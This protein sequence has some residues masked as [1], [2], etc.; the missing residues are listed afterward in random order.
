MSCKF[1]LLCTDAFFA[2]CYSSFHL[3]VLFSGT[4]M[5]FRSASVLASFFY[6]SLARVLHFSLRGVSVLSSVC[7]SFQVFTFLSIFNTAFFARWP[8]RSCFQYS[9]FPRWSRGGR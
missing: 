7:A 2:G 6:F 1:G 8:S 3:I 9:I 4:Y 5:R